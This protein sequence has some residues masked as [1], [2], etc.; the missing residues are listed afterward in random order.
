MQ[1]KTLR[2]GILGINSI[3]FARHPVSECDFYQ[4]IVKLFDEFDV[5]WFWS[6]FL[7]GPIYFQQH[8][9]LSNTFPLEEN[10]SGK[11]KFIF[12]GR[13]LQKSFYLWYDLMKILTLL[14]VSEIV[15]YRN[16]KSSGFTFIDWCFENYYYSLIN[17]WWIHCPVVRILSTILIICLQRLFIATGP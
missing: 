3:H 17:L 6:C 8:I 5:I 2:K 1:T 15:Y 11:I 7:F 12:M 16:G 10:K 9:W 13:Q 14:F 4:E